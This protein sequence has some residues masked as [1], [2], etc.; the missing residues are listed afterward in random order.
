MITV[1]KIF[2]EVRLVRSEFPEVDEIR[3]EAESDEV[4]HT[5]LEEAYQLTQE[6][7]EELKHLP[8]NI[9]RDFG[10]LIREVKSG[11]RD[12]FQDDD[13]KSIKGTASRISDMVS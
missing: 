10:D 11:V 12:Y 2:D 3:E 4:Y 7:L 13:D 1:S 8:S 6:A 9:S 5:R